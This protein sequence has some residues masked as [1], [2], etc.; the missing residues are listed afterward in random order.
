VHTRERRREVGI[1]DDDPLFCV[2]ALGDLLVA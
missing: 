2:G 1:G